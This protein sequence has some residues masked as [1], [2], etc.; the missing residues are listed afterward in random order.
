MDDFAKK[1][2][3]IYEEMAEIIISALENGEISV[4]DSQKAAEFVLQK[5]DEVSSHDQLINFLGEISNLW[6]I[7][8]SLHLKIKNE[9]VKTQDQAQIEQIQNSLDNL[10]DNQQGQ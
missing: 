2:N 4:E 5:F 9:Q 7:Y 6:P 1:K 3:Q 10:S 8:Q